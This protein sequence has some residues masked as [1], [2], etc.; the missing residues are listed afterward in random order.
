[1][2]VLL[3]EAPAVKG[4]ASLLFPV[5]GVGGWVGGRVAAQADR[6]MRLALLVVRMYVCVGVGD[7]ICVLVRF[8]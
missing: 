1:M 5:G 3:Q 6:S 4:D 2:E 7:G 8:S